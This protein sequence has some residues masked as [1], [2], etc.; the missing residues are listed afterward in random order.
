MRWLAVAAALA[1]AAAQDMGGGLPAGMVPM[2]GGGDAD[3]VETHN[4]EELTAATYEER[5]G[6]YE[7]YLVLF[8]RRGQQAQQAEKEIELAATELAHDEG[9][10]GVGLIDLE[11]DETKGVAKKAQVSE[12]RSRRALAA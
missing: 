6:E 11:S 5:L 2:G 1:L 12:R 8:R 7:L 10:M 3:A 4:A 9:A